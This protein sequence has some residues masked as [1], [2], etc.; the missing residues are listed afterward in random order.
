MTPWPDLNFCNVAASIMEALCGAAIQP[1]SPGRN[2]EVN[3]WHKQWWR[4]AARPRLSLALQGGGA[5]GAYTW[6]VLDRLLEEDLDLD[7][8]S[9]TSAG[10]MNA[11]ALA[12]G[13][14]TGGA[15]G[16]RQSLASFWNAVAA[17]TPLHMD[18][19]QSFNAAGD[20]SLAMPMS[21]MLGF[22]KFLSPSQMNPFELNPLRDLVRAQFDFERLRRDCKLKL[23]I[24]ATRVDSGKLRLFRTAELTEEALL[25]SA[26]LPTLQHAV[27]IDGDAYWDG[28]FSANPAISPLLYECTTPDVL[29][30]LLN[31]L[32]RPDAPC[33]A[34]EIAVR[35]MDLGFATPLL[36]EMRAIAQARDYIDD[37]A[38]WLPGGRLERRLTEMRFHMVDAVELNAADSASKLNATR[39]F[40]TD[41]RDLGRARAARWLG[42][43]RPQVG[44][45]GTVDLAA[46]FA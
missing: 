18:L 20:G 38:G 3:M 17:G 26:C 11:V 9:G 35:S 46:V 27:A 10:A 28:G 45:R 6:G 1:C 7:G 23:F 36:R 14:T 25:A 13:W 5:H 4:R 12:Q 8:V 32:S 43:H 29:L 34:E 40:L 41:L 39:G 24:A 22:T 42:E 19:L 30:V 44:R 16:A 31:P 15:E 2:A 37:A 21:L 33:S